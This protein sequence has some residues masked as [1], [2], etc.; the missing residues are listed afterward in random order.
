MTY[1]ARSLILGPLILRDREA[2]KAAAQ[3]CIKRVI[4][5][6]VCQLDSAALNP[7]QEL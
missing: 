4:V 2:M 3:L 5:A 1:L 7:G 6:A